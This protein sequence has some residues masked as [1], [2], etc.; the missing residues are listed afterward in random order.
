M[1]IQHCTKVKSFNFFTHTGCPQKQDT[2]LNLVSVRDKELITS[3]SPVA[4]EDQDT[5]W[6]VSIYVYRVYSA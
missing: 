3:A 4:G 2:A 5:L 6:Q 1:V